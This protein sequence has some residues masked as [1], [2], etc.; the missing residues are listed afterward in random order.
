MRLVVKQS[1]PPLPP[2]HLANTTSGADLI[3]V[4]LLSIASNTLDMTLAETA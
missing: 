2:C 4:T 1:L 3:S